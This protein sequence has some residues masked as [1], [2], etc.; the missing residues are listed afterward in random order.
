MHSLGEAA[1]AA[2]NSGMSS[3]SY[4]TRLA[5]AK[6]LAPVLLGC[7]RTGDANDPQVY[8]AAI[9]AV[10]SDYAPEVQRLVC[11][12]R[13]GLP[14]RASWLPTVAEVKSA[15]NTEA[16]R[17]ERINRYQ[18]MSRPLK[19]IAGPRTSRANVLIR[20]TAPMYA[21]AIK[22]AEDDSAHPENW[23][24]DAAG[25]Y[26]TLDWALSNGARA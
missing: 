6:R 13:A 5:E 20:P 19:R 1:S 8:V 2:M 24:T 14:S 16:S 23:R 12:P 3:E 7:Y 22:A 15:C 10:L 25:I 4:E 21:D 11:D 17:L 9:I 26:V 18:A